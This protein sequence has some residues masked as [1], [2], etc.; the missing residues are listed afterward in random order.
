MRLALSKDDL[1]TSFTPRE[2]VTAYSAAQHV[3]L[4]GMQ[5]CRQVWTTAVLLPSRCACMRVD[6]MLQARLDLATH[7]EAVRLRLDDVGASHQEEGRRTLQLPE[8]C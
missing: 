5:Q 7:L 2:S 6:Y 3:L 8:E 1:K 4:G